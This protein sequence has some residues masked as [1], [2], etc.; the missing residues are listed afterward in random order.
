MNLAM[1][2]IVFYSQ[3]IW[4]ID[5]LVVDNH[6]FVNED[7]CRFFFRQILKSHRIVTLNALDEYLREKALK[8]ILGWKEE[9]L[10]FARQQCN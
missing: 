4:S 7:D 9:M 6:H 8:P 5:V 10:N 1:E 2:Q 3:W